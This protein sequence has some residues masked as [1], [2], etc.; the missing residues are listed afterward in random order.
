MNNLKYSRCEACRADEPVL[1]NKEINELKPQIPEWEVI[2]SNDIKHLCRSF[3]F[4]D[5]KEAL[6]FTN[7]I[8]DSA[9]KEGHHPSIV[10]KWGKVMV[11]WWTHKIK[12]LH[13]NDFIMAAKTDGIY[14]SLSD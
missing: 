14:R 3:I 2:E 6:S 13:R 5:F 8:G 7:R 4:K 10:T 9:E 11:S 12:G 1:N